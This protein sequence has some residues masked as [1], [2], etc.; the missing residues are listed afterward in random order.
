MFLSRFRLLGRLETI[1][2]LVL[3]LA[4]A[5][6]SLALPARY[7]PTAVAGDNDSPLQIRTEGTCQDAAGLG[8]LTFGLGLD[9]TDAG[10]PD[11]NDSTNP[12]NGV[13]TVSGLPSGAT[14]VE[15]WLYWNGSDLGNS[16][17]D[18]PG[19]FNPAVNDGDPTVRLNG[20]QVANVTRIGGPA[21][22][23]TSNFSYAYR[24]DVSG[25]VT[26]N[27]TYIL[28]GIDNLN[29]YINGAELV[30]VYSSAARDPH[31][32]AIA[33]GM[34]LAE[35]ST[36]PASGPGTTAV[37]YQ[38]NPAAVA[39]TA[40]VTLFLGGAGF[41]T[42]NNA[43]WYETGNNAN[44][45]SF[46]NPTI[47]GRPTA[48]Q[49]LNAF[50]GLNNQT[51]PPNGYWDSYTFTV[52]VPPGNTWLAVQVE[53]KD[54]TD[55]QRL[56]WVG[57][58]MEMP[59]A[60]P[61][62]TVTKTRTSPD[63]VQPGE[64]VTFQIVVTNTG[65]TDIV[66]ATLR[67][68]YDTTYLS[69]GFAGNFST[70]A[71]N[72]NVNDGQIDWTDVTGGGSLAPGAS[73]TVTVRFTAVTSTD[74]ITGPPPKRTVN[75]ALV[76]AAVDQ[77]GLSAAAPQS[78]DDNVRITSP[79]LSVQKTLLIPADGST[80]VG[81]QVQYRIRITNTG[82]T[83]LNTVPLVD[84]YD[85][86]Y[87]TYGFG[88]NFST[89][90]SNDNVNDGTLNWSDVTGAGS[91]APGAS[92]D[93]IVNFTAA[94]S[95][96][97]LPNQQTLNTATV[98]G[99]VDENGDSPPSASDN[100]PVEIG[101]PG[102]SVQKTLLIPSGGVAL[103]GGQVQYR[104]RI[105]NTGDTTL[106]T[107]PLVDT[108][109]TT[110]LTYGFGGSF[111]TPASDDN[112]NDGTLNWSD[113]T[114]SGSLAP[115]AFTDV[116]VNFTARASTLGLPNQQTLNT[117]TAGPATDE[118]NET[119]NTA[120][121]D[122]PIRIVN[123]A[124]I[125]DYVWYDAN[126]DGIQDVTESG[127]GNVTLAL[128]RDN[129]TNGSIDGGDTLIG[130]QTT[131]ADGGY[132]FT[133][134][135]PGQYIVDVTDANGILTGLT[136][137][138]GPQSQAA[139][140]VVVVTAGQ[141]YRDA[142]FGYVRQPSAG[143]GIVGDTVWYDQNQN[144]IQD[145][146]EPG[147]PGV[148][149]QLRDAGNNLIA[150]TTTDVNGHY[151]FVNV[152]PGTYYVQVPTPPPGLSPS[153][154]A[155]NPT[156]VFV[157]AAGDQ[158][159][160]ADIGFYDATNTVLGTIGN[161]VFLD[162]N[163]NG[164]FQVGTDSPLGG[165]SVDLIRD[166]NNNGVW[167]AGEPIIA[168]T[169]TVPTLG[170]NNGNYLF[171]GVPA[172]R[173][174]VRV[175]DT[176]YVLTDY[177]VTVLGTSDTDNHNQA[178]PYPVILP[179]GGN[180]LTADFGYVLS[181]V[182]PNGVIG[183]QVWYDVDGNGIYS[184]ANGD[185]GIA[186]VTVELR[187][188]NT[189]NLIATTTT[190][191]AGD[192][193]FTGLAAGTYRVQVTDIYGV[194]NGYLVSNLGPTPGADHN[195]QA[196]PYTV[197]LPAGGVNLTADF[198][199]TR[200]GAIGDFIWY[201]ADADG[202]EDVGEPGIPNVTVALYHT[203]PD[204]L[205]GTSDDVL[206]ATTVTDADGGY[207][208]TGLLPGT[209]FVDVTDT[210]GRLSGM[211]HIVANQSRPDPT[212]TIT[213]GVGQVY[214]DADFG[215]VRQPAPGT[216][217]VGDLVWYDQN[218]NGIQDPG[219][220]G[221]AGLTVQLRRASDNAVIATTTTDSNG[222]Y[223][224]TNVAPGSYYVQLASVPSGLSPSPAAPNPT[225][226]FTV[227]AGDQYL[228]ADIGLYDPPG[229]SN[230]LGTIGNLVFE[231]AD[232]DG[233]YNA[234]SEVP[235]VGVSVDLILDSNN[236]GVWEVGEP[237]IA[238]ATTDQ[239]GL[240]L[241]T[242]VPAGNY[243]VHV[244]DT[245][246]VLLDYVKSPVTGPANTDNRN[247]ADPYRVVLPAGGTN[248]TA[249][250]GYYRVNRQDIGVLGNQVWTEVDYN[251]VFNP[252][253]RD[254]GQPGVTVDL[255][256]NG[257]FYG[258]TTTGAGGDYSFTA[259]PSGVYTVTVSDAF[260]VLSGYMDTVF[261]PNQTADNNNKLQP[262]TIALPQAG[263]NLTADFGYIEPVTIGDFIFVD[264]N[265]N[266]IQDPGET[267]GIANVPI[268]A[269]N[270]STS[271]VFTT[272]SGPTG[273][274]LF[275]NLPP[276]TYSVQTPASIPL[277]LRTTGVPIVRS[278]P[279]GTVDLNFDFG[280]INP[281]A[282]TVAHFGYSLEPAGVTIH[283]TTVF[284]EAG[285]RFYLYR[286]LS[287]DGARTLLTPTGIAVGGNPQGSSYRFTDTT[288]RPGQ[289]YYYWLETRPQGHIHGPLIVDYRAPVPGGIK[290][291]LPQLSRA[292]R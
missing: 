16:P 262:Y 83:T 117:A 151:L 27:G 195:N 270:L 106:N 276:G 72:D 229:G 84:T 184:P 52:L 88:G 226:V 102:I 208:F 149:V 75:T 20:T 164:I 258:R 125:G 112:V 289:T 69:Y 59:L 121:D 266:G 288:A 173:Y 57:S 47:I 178:Q 282:T 119:T 93:V 56:E 76:L 193:V 162:T 225:A 234:L 124:A 181:G 2:R 171:T 89:P 217:I 98:S 134:L 283:W 22:W 118:N 199:Y 264:P 158:Y 55:P 35:G 244:S 186:G 194:L 34:D 87:L 180:V 212:G 239:N 108:Y 14:I 90:A 6:S 271:Q 142:D 168:T 64:Q 65:N 4:L 192:Y 113:V 249:D 62:Y 128:W 253:H 221:A 268:T 122:E 277:Y 156:A 36:G 240:Y 245:N 189:N 238:T 263:V 284:E 53:S 15:A 200:P 231:D 183:N 114:G 38:F 169:T 77:N 68:L 104:I 127:I 272:L 257:V 18:N 227:A 247:Q 232:Q 96:Q 60:C 1:L 54:G 130:I 74:P 11:P 275:T 155:P 85:T 205:P 5:L 236:N 215:Y 28:T 291:F 223:F 50:T 278:L 280:Y 107:V 66:T 146:G 213:L 287:E 246:S 243:L 198:G 237:I 70:P 256:R 49:V 279:A 210:L 48:T 175:S 33:E 204:G 165:V 242:G 138:L 292:S 188:A 30:I 202:I 126:A 191:A 145:P 219:E 140:F 286:S 105:T 37:V 116:I 197:V 222:N 110:Y 135:L 233:A 61:E 176:I 12:T 179:A 187:D 31:Y 80:K 21:F 182:D 261:P 153:P 273:F 166:S 139:P 152:A 109:D 209:Y 99:A 218:T 174:L 129:N 32:F 170:A 100:E 207:L 123:D 147:I 224:F 10:D 190:G 248:L 40:T 115:G 228:D 160:D 79:G 86:T 185:T 78:D 94:A 285:D 9:G 254:I 136:H 43:L 161:L 206:L 163:G 203:G 25:I 250:F 41:A 17:E 26:G 269:T 95:T 235:I 7:L 220:P 103:V 143:T 251:G 101:N 230:V 252:A 58:T 13:F 63:F 141:V 214:K 24:A 137:T 44:L 133:G 91:L 42:G 82:D 3:A 148:T 23:Q 46:P 19:L 51:T 73:I 281:T 177:S 132:L 144:G 131:G 267:I 201:D 29:N 67:D 216:A 157:L 92:I 8:V 150:T 71:S 154:A 255:Y 159:L 172:G 274:Y 211:A 259:L 290:L 81:G 111:S 260:G 241:F 167:D 196:Q 97:A 265:A 39:R 45:P 120:T